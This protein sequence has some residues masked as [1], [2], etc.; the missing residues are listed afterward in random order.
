MSEGIGE[1]ID[2][3]EG[4]ENEDIVLHPG[5]CFGWY[6]HVSSDCHPSSC[7]RSEWCRTY[8]LN[9]A[10]QSEKSIKKDLEDIGQDSNKNI[11]Q[12]KA[13][14][15]AIADLGRQAFFDKIVNFVAGNVNHDNIKYNP[16]RDSASIKVGGKVVA[17]LNKKRS[18]VLIKI[19]GRNKDGEEI[20]VPIGEVEETINSQIVSFLKENI[21]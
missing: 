1:K 20:K 5:D 6:S 18:Q 4:G 7:L 9:R 11:T 10:N 13:S 8:T 12:K 3:P 17:F 15:S 2:N 21:E 14:K 16:K 19:G